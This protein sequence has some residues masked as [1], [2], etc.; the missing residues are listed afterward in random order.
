MERLLPLVALLLV[1]LAM[2]LIMAPAAYHRQAE[3]G[4][5]SRRFVTVA[6]WL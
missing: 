2:V 3:R 6:F 5:I 4:V 1:T